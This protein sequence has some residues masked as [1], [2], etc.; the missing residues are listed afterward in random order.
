MS[1]K[2]VARIMCEVSEVVTLL[3]YEYYLVLVHSLCVCA[4]ICFFLLL[5]IK[6][7]LVQVF[8]V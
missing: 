3:Q 6:N 7:F 4:D 2:D 1:V 5:F 8:R